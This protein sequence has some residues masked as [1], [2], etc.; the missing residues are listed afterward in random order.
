VANSI[1]YGFQQ[2]KDLATTRAIELRNDV[3]QSAIALSVADHNQQVN[4]LLSLFCEQTTNYKMKFTAASN[5]RLQA[6]DE[7]S[8]ALPVKGSTY[9]VDFPIQKGDTAWGS[10]L[11]TRQKM[12]VL[13][14]NN[15]VST[16][17]S[18]DVNWMA[19]HVLAAL[20]Y[21]G[22]GWTFDDPQYGALTAKGMANGDTVTYFRSG[23]SASIDT[24]QLGQAAAIADAT[25]PYPTIYAE[26][27][28]HPENAG[29]DF[30]ALIATDQVATTEALASFAPIS[31][32]NVKPGSA[33]AVAVGS[34]GDI[35]PGSSMLLGRA[36]NMWIAEWPRIPAGYIVALATGGPRPL[37]MRQD[38]ESEL[39]GF[40]QADPRI[41][42]PHSE[43]QYFRRA[44]FGAWNRVGAVVME[45]ADATYDIPTGFE[46]PMR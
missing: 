15:A 28:E 7:N 3:L 19:D 1:L 22:A 39:Q 4:R 43:N 33:S 21:N 40:V 16:M 26:L 41:D 12:T 36:G 34:P 20:F 6:G 31:D 37:A 10:N 2:L 23:G 46:S 24:H 44:G 30:I 9:D 45:I 29:G 42:F 14:V 17:L 32:P 8:R 35:L 18:G 25:N 5:N 38:P 27:S 11:I 13:E